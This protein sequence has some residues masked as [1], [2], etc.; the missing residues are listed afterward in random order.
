MTI[1]IIYQ[2]YCIT[3]RQPLGSYWTVKVTLHGKLVHQTEQGVEFVTWDQATA[4]AIRKIKKGE[5]K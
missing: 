1:P 5:I 4:D 3:T 2:D